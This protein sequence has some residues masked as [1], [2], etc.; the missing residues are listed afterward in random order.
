[1]KLSEQHIGATVFY[2]DKGA[3]IPSAAII[4]Y[5]CGC[6]CM[7][8]TLEV[9]SEAY[10]YRERIANVCYYVNHNAKRSRWCFRKLTPEEKGE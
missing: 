6:G 1:M 7:L 10:P 8:A 9:F 4:T 3:R 2:Y 5:V